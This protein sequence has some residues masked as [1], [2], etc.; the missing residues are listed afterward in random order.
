MPLLPLALFRTLRPICIALALGLGLA[1]GRAEAEGPVFPL[2][3]DNPVASLPSVEQRRGAPLEFGYWMMEAAAKGDEALQ[4][5]NFPQA[6]KYFEALAAA[7]PDRATVHAKLCAA[8]EG[9]HESQKAIFSC[10]K[11]I[12]KEGVTV[13]D[14]TRLIGLVVA[15]PGS[16][17]ANGVREVDG[18]IEHLSTQG[19]P[20][21]LVAEQRCALAE[22]LRDTKRLRTCTAILELAGQRGGRVTAYQWRLAMLEKDTEE[23]RRLLALAREDA[24]F[25]PASLAHLE[26]ETQG[27]ERSKLPVRGLIALAV[28]LGAVALL[29]VILVRRRGAQYT[30]PIV[31]APTH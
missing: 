9:A 8:Y 26:A 31:P 18:L 14:V 30:R 29:A 20:P 6:A 28:A 25:T 11:A 23:A 7:V 17:D 3:H 12:G 4:E 16:L 27:L 22:K 21:A 1:A 19:V 5:Q 2:N 15:E 10:R 13:G 24:A